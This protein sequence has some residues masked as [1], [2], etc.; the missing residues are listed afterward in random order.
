MK[1]LILFALTC[2]MSATAFA[3]ETYICTGKTD[4]SRESEITLSF[5]SD[6]KVDVTTEDGGEYALDYARV[7]SKNTFYGNYEYDGYGGSVELKLPKNFTTSGSN[8]AEEFKATLVIEVYSEL[9]HV[10]GETFN[11]DCQRIDN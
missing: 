9:G 4:T 3:G 8:A 6:Q 11:G 1:N 5:E 10:G 7:T 2:S